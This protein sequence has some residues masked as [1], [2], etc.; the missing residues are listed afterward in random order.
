MPPM[1]ALRGLGCAMTD[2]EHMERELLKSMER[3]GILGK[4]AQYLY[5]LA[6]SEGEKG[7]VIA[8]ELK[9]AKES[10]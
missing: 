3:Q 6:V 2:I 10:Q 1:N 7:A 8:R 4:M 9:K 5:I